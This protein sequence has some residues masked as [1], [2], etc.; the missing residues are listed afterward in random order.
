MGIFTSKLNITRGKY[1]L[2]MVSGNPI[3]KSDIL[4]GA[5]NQELMN[6]LFNF[7]DVEGGPD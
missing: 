4:K 5:K 6:V 2:N 3:Q 7:F 1:N